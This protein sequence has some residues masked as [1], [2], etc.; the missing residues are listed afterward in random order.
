ELIS[1]RKSGRSFLH[2][3]LEQL[4]DLLWYSAKSIETFCNDKGYVTSHRS[5]PSAGARHPIDLLIHRP[6]VGGLEYYNPFEH[7]LCA[8]GLEEEIV[9]QFIGHIQVSMPDQSGTLIWFLAHPNRTT[10][11][12]ENADSLIWRD[13]GA[14]IQSIQ[15]TAAAMGLG[16]CAIGTLGEPFLSMMFDQNATILSAGGIIVGNNLV[17]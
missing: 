10:A 2:L 3:E 11:K 9:L 15:L 16:S 17:L 4:A 12:Y 6:Q 14:L 8:L 5:S 13:A 1:A 7:S